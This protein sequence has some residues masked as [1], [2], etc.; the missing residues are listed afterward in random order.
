MNEQ[1]TK[2]IVEQ[3]VEDLFTGE[4]H[5]PDALVVRTLHEAAAT[6]AIRNGCSVLAMLALVDAELF[7][8]F[9]DSGRPYVWGEAIALPDEAS[10]VLNGFDGVA[11]ELVE[12]YKRTGGSWDEALIARIQHSRR[13]LPNGE[14][15]TVEQT[16]EFVEVTLGWLRLYEMALQ[17]REKAVRH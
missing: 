3:A 8:T 16:A 6:S 11:R 15:A 13:V 9:R 5:D 10:S 2:R 1:L 7:V 14:P 4:K 12:H 17:Q